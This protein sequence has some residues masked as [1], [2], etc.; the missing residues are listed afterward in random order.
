MKLFYF[1]GITLP[2]FCVRSDCLRKPRYY[3]ETSFHHVMVQGDEKKYVFKNEKNKRKFLYLLKHN[4]FR[5]DVEIIAYCLMDNH[6]HALLF[7]P[8]VSRIS[9]MMSQCNT[10]FGLYFN[11]QREKIGHVFRERF[12]S[13]GIYTKSHLINC[14]K[15]IHENPVRAGICDRCNQYSFSSYNGFKRMSDNLRQICELSDYEMDE[16]M[17]NSHTDTV[18]LDDEYSKED[19]QLV[20][21]EILRKHHFLRDDANSVVIIYKELKKRCRIS[22]TEIANL[23]GMNRF[24]L[25]RRLKKMGIKKNV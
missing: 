10:S 8:N 11:K 2:F 4:A 18:Y 9:K 24:S 12:R 5:N 19:I 3:Y 14:I 22:D 20:A 17:E 16:I 23:L 21:E 25:I 6:V 13:E 15:Y 7:C 1:Y